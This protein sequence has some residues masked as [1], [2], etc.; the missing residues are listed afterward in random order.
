MLLADANYPDLSFHVLLPALIDAL[1]DVEP[2]G[3]MQKL[4]G[5]GLSATPKN[6]SGEII[7]QKDFWPTVAAGLREGDV[8]I[9]ET[10]TSSFGILDSKLPKGTTHCS[11]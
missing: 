7:T 11:Q 8:T 5:A 2:K 4:E 3:R 10:G 9:A 6:I 1:R